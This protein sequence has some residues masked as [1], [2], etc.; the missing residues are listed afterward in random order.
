MAKIILYNPFLMKI[1]QKIK[2]IIKN[3]LL[4]L[5][6]LTISIHIKNVF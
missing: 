1:N 5:P 2:N 3:F 4:I 6:I